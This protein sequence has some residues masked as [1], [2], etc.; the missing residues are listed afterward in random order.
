MSTPYEGDRYKVEESDYY[1]ITGTVPY[2]RFE[3]PAY[4]VLDEEDGGYIA[5]C[6]SEKQANE[7]VDVL[8]ANVAN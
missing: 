1:T 2:A 8:N 6:T 5:F 4:C 7:L 3:K